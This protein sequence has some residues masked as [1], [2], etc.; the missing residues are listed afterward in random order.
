MK[1]RRRLFWAVAVS[2]ALHLLWLADIEWR[3]SLAGDDTGDVLEQQEAEAVKRVRLA[4]QKPAPAASPVIPVVTLLPAGGLTPLA[5]EPPTPRPRPAPPAPAPVPEAAAT[6]DTGTDNASTPAVADAPAHEPEPPVELPPSFPVSVLAIQRANY[7]GFRM[8]LRQQWLMEGDRYVI[9]NE[10][11]KFGFKA[12]ISSE[13]RV[14][15]EGLRPERYRLLLN[16]ALKQFADFDRAGGVLVH[17][18]DDS[19]RTTPLSDDM[20]DM[21]SLPYHVAVSYE[22]KQEQRLRV[23][24]GSSVYD[25]VLRLVSEDRLRLPGGELRTLHLVGSRTHRDGSQQTGY[26]IW[27]A[28]DYLNF[29]VR[30]RGPDSKGNILEMSVLSLTFDGRLV[31]GKDIREEALPPEPDALPPGLADE[32]TEGLL[33]APAENNPAASEASRPDESGTATADD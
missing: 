14:S 15:P 20:Q 28:P 32:L 4:L 2:A 33:P 30:F 19:R 6:P 11:S 17:G 5:E 18:R 10:A 3:W 24:T 1:A 31:F 16:N 29:P 25:I 13:G 9:R 27:L 22:G 21:A 8:E 7:Y 12:V 23:T 26:D